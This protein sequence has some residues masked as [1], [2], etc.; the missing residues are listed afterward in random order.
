M[1]SSRDPSQQT[2]TRT[3]ARIRSS[4]TAPSRKNQAPEEIGNH[5]ASALSYA[6]LKTGKSYPIASW[7]A[8]S[9]VP[10]SKI[11]NQKNF[12]KFFATLY[13]ICEQKMTTKIRVIAHNCELHDTLKLP[14]NLTTKSIFCQ[15]PKSLHCLTFFLLY[16]KKISFKTA[17][18]NCSFMHK[19]AVFQV[20][21]LK[22]QKW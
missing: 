20:T 15:A 1:T 21:A 10:Y 4:K 3:H 17:L 12:L 2:Q 16:I 8:Q 6:I 14:H 18:K 13:K 9:L 22:S 7:Q 5:T 19:Y 11:A